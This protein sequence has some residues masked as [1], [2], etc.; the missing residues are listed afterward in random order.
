MTRSGGKPHRPKVHGISGGP[1]DRFREGWAIIP[2]ITKPH[3]WKRRDLERTYDSL[4]GLNIGPTHPGV[5]P[6]T[7]GVFMV[8]RCK[9][10]VRKRQRIAPS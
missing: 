5:D 3:Y 2:F 7:P 9:H 1:I 8:E 4:C 10:C 6:L